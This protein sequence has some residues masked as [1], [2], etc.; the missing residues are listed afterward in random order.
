MR[1]FRQLLAK[2][3]FRRALEL[4]RPNEDFTSQ[5]LTPSHSQSVYWVG[6]SLMQECVHV[7]D[8][9]VSLFNLMTCFA[10]SR[11]FTFEMFDHTLYGAPLSLQ[12]RGKPHS[13]S[14]TAPEMNTKRAAFS[15]EA[16]HFDT[17]VL[18]EVVPVK[19][20]IELEYSA[21]YLQQFYDTIRSVNA[22]ARIY[23]YES[24]DYLHGTA[25]S[26]AQNEFDWGVAMDEQR[27]LWEK[28]SDEASFGAAI[29]PS[30]KE[31][32]KALIWPNTG[33][34]HRDPI[35]LVPVGQVFKRLYDV[36]LDDDVGE[37]L[38]LANGETLRFSD[39]F[40]NP[41]ENWYEAKKKNNKNDTPSTLTL[42]DA[43]KALDD[44]H[45]SA[46]G[47]YIVAL[48]HFATLYRVSPVGLPAITVIGERLADQLQQIVWEIVCVD[49]RTGV[50]APKINNIK[51]KPY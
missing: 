51:Q 13:F 48:V 26:L 16:V 32:L 27:S 4:R 24:W 43:S 35:F 21:Y 6:H 28:I 8:Q 22:N 3:A 39:L 14:R 47:I 40:S 17:F 38:K 5:G 19:N 49:P 46:M 7:D 29:T 33:C 12:W 41:Y 1:K 30:I 44:I 31:Q 9:Q 23:V 37:N 11:Q 45:P 34:A 15:R 50:V 10:E 20:V 42:R 36:L 2:F 18:T 25:S